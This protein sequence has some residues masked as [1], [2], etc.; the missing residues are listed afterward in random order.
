MIISLI[1]GTDSQRVHFKIDTIAKLTT[2]HNKYYC[3]LTTM[4]CESCYPKGKYLV[5]L[6][7]KLQ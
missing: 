1:F 2:K 7:K 5:K 3:K 4:C 6:L